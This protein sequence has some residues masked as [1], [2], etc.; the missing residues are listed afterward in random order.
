M[1][2]TTP[3]LRGPAGDLLGAECAPQGVH[4][5]SLHLHSGVRPADRRAVL[6]ST[7]AAGGEVSIGAGGRD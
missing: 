5:A 2:P 7:G 1:Q 3:E 4:H 6:Q